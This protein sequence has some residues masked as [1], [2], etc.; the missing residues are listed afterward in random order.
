MAKAIVSRDARDDLSDIYDYIAADNVSAAF[1]LI[2]R[3]GK[4]FVT[5][6]AN[7]RMGRVRPELGERIRSIPDGNYIIFYRRWA[8]TILIVR[9]LH[10][11]RDLDEIFS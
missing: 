5:V 3:F 11:A 10:A 9:V 2:D 7:P 1:R 6:A 4:I 8:D